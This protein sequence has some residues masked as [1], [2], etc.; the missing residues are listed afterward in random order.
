MYISDCKQI[1]LDRFESKVVC[2]NCNF[3][4]W[5]KL[6]TKKMENAKNRDLMSQVKCPNCKKTSNDARSEN[7][8]SF[9]LC[10]VSEN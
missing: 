9:L 10:G 3:Q 8:I 1:A 4:K 5:W 6:N 7:S 2:E